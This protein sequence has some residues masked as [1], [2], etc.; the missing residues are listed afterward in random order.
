MLFRF[1]V[2]VISLALAHPAALRSQER[3]A[4]EFIRMIEQ[5]Q[6]GAVAGE[7]ASLTIEA[8]MERFGV[9]GVSIAVIHDFDIHWAK[10]Y[11]VA[12]TETGAPVDTET[13]FQAASISKPV[14][15]MAVLR[16]TQD[17]IFGLDDDI[18]GIL[19]S[20]KLEGGEFTRE[21][22]VTP[23]MLTSHT[24]GLGDGFGFPGYDPSTPVPTALQILQA[25]ELSNVRPLFMERPPMSLMEYSGGGVTVMQ[26]ALSDA[27]GRPFQ[28]ILRETVLQPIGMENST[29]E[30]PLPADRDRNAARAHSG[31]GE[32]MGPKWRVYPE[33]AAAGLWTTP[34][35]LARFIIEVQRS[36]RG[37]SNRV[38]SRTTV[39]EMVSPVGVGDYGVGFAVR[40]MGE[41][42]YF[43]HGGSNWGFQATIL[44]HKVKG[45][46][47]AIMT[48]GAR[49]GAVV[50]ELS[51]RIQSAYEWDSLAEPAPRGYQPPPARTEIR[52]PAEKLMEYV[53]EYEM[54]PATTLT[55]TM[56]DGRLQGQPTGQQRVTIYAEA[57]D[58]FFLRAFDAQLLFTR[59]PD[60]EVTGV[61]FVE[62]GAEQGSFPKVR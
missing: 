39:Q 5:P 4:A 33:L 53:G 20:W 26:Q 59:G 23:R 44:G 28:D 46:G 45:Y 7:P 49:G 47:L 18:N 57:E 2:V 11:G 32:A 35:D 52:L 15:A 29:F 6:P 60:G 48:N 37:E 9:P 1:V 61:T 17:G 51:R 24:S 27:L 22:P 38:L 14:A 41:G 58:R 25:H 13:L 34:T 30:Q 40:K 50:A 3:S 56:E 62:E 12:D 36:A 42:W 54:A 19:R 16:A 21:R 43:A 31:E 8:L 55:I 10:G